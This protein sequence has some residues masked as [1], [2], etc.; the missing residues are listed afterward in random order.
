MARGWESKAVADQIEEAEARRRDDAVRLSDLSPD[1][2]RRS[3]RLES[4]KL[5]RSRTLDQ[6]ERAANSRYRESL[7]RALAAVENDMEELG[8]D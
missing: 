5:L 8:E 7:L 6:L 2:R 3:E 4:L 1:M